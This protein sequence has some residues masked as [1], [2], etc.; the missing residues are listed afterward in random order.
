MDAF[1]RAL[2]VGSYL[3]WTEEQKQEWLI[4]ELNNKRPIYRSSEEFKDNENV[5]EVLKTFEVAVRLGS[6]SL[7]AYIISMAQYPSDILAVELLQKQAGSTSPQRVAPL[8]E[9]KADLERSGQVIERLFQIPWYKNHIKGKQEV[10]LGY[11]DSAK[12]AGRLTSVWSL[13]KAQEELV[14]ISKKHGVA[15]S[16]NTT[17]VSKY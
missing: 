9:T 15:V 4:S 3:D 10:M 14:A 17:K 8:F 2:G 13:Y 5:Y 12:D 6:S 7:G 1:T 11:S 16:S